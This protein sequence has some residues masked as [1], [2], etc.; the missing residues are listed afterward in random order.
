MISSNSS[1]SKFGL[2]RSTRTISRRVLMRVAI[3]ECRVSISIPE[4]RKL[5][6]VLCNSVIS[7]GPRSGSTTLWKVCA[8]TAETIDFASV[9][10]IRTVL[11]VCFCICIAALSSLAEAIAERGSTPVGKSF[12]RRFPRVKDSSASAAER[13]ILNDAASGVVSLIFAFNAQCP[14]ARVSMPMIQKN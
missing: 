5:R 1:S 3:L 8:T 14:N 7:S 12:T 10:S 11:S 9:R 2:W 6:A 13:T 4:L